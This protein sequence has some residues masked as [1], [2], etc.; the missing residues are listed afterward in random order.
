M[1]IIIIKNILPDNTERRARN[2]RQPNLHNRTQSKGRF[3]FTLVMSGYLF[4]HVG[5]W[6]L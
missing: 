6:D 3:H 2:K 5:H 1:N 4:G